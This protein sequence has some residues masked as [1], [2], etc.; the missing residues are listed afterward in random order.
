LFAG[1]FLPGKGR[2]CFPAPSF[3]LICK[4]KVDPFPGKFHGPFAKKWS[5]S[6]PSF[7][8]PSFFGSLFPFLHEGE[9]PLLVGPRACT[10]RCSPTASFRFQILP[11]RPLTCP[12]AIRKLLESFPRHVP[13]DGF[14]LPTLLAVFP[15]RRVRGFFATRGSFSPGVFGVGYYLPLL[16]G[17]RPFFFCSKLFGCLFPPNAFQYSTNSATEPSMTQWVFP[18][19]S[20]EPG[21]AAISRLGPTGP[22]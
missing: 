1:P 8:P 21:V 2:L 9:F 5:L 15:P 12:P 17:S 19:S 7:S 16:R 6:G 22:L 3:L 13:P 4:S 18:F 11:G 20:G 14:K 10:F